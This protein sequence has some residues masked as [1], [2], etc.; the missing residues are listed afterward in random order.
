MPR[1]K[2]DKKLSR[3]RQ[4]KLDDLV[5][6]LTRVYREDP[7]YGSLRAL[8]EH[9]MRIQFGAADLEH[10]IEGLERMIPWDHLRPE[11]RAGWLAVAR[12]V[13]DMEESERAE[14]V[15]RD[16]PVQVEEN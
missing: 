15:R 8:A 14:V 6:R 9:L 11:F 16:I 2:H 1:G 4:E 10:K 5:R 3:N 13:A 12:R 7:G